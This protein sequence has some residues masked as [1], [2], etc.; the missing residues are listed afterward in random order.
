MTHP[1]G[2]DDPQV[3]AAI[4]QAIVCAANDQTA[5]AVQILADLVVAFPTATSVHGYLAWFLLQMGRYD[6][7]IQHS[8]R[9]VDLAPNSERASLVY[10]H[11]LWKA[12]QRI[13]ALDEMRRFLLI[14][15]SEEYSKII[16]DLE[17]HESEIGDDEARERDHEQGR[18]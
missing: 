12:G 1:T 5:L 2:N 6:E 4:N 7:A 10:F 14:R 16:E 9:A 15:P 3:V 11:A 8:L 17:L 13:P 18:R